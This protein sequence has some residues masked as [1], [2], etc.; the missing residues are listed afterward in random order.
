MNTITRTLAELDPEA[1]ASTEITAQDE[2]LL[3]AIM[4][5]PLPAP[6]RKK[7]TH[8]RRT[9]IVVG[10]VAATVALGLT[11]VDIGGQHVGASPAAAELL[12]RAAKV[13]LRQSDP[14]VGPGQYLRKT[15]VQQTWNE[16]V[17]SD[18]KPFAFQ[19]RWTMQIWIPY[20]R[21]KDWVRRERTTF[22]SSTS[23][24]AAE[25]VRNEAKQTD[26]TWMLPSWSNKAGKSYIEMYDPDWYAT[27][28][29][30]PQKLMAKLKGEDQGD[31]S[32]TDYYFGEVFSEVLRS[33]LA[34]ADIRAAL[35]RGLAET[36]GMKVV[37]NVATLDGRRGVAIS[38]G[39]GM[40]MVF[41][42]K[43]GAYIGERA[44]DPDFPDLRGP[45]AGEPT[46]LTSN[47]VDVVD[48]APKPD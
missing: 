12:E 32:S 5:E 10:A 28:P 34:P 2:D 22:V 16:R 33:G 35:F 23:R 14:V 46:F 40:Q 47:H 11:K 7:R 15:L 37:H 43:T 4:A 6:A 13:T 31:G 30:D 18:G 17:G 29:R 3:L 19:T 9:L 36:P 44:T 42:Q 24:E 20:D 26:G 38:Y 21:D 8:V 41:D 39:K 45:D 25:R 48:S 1:G 27:L